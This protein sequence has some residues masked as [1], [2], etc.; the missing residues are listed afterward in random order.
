MKMQINKIEQ[1]QAKSGAIFHKLTIDGKT[2]NTFEPLGDLKVG[3]IV[4]CEFVQSGEYTNIKT[5]KKTGEGSIN[6]PLPI[7]PTAVVTG[8]IAEVRTI[9]Q[10]SYEVGKAGNRHTIRY[11]DAEDL[12]RQI[13]ALK[14]AGFWDEEVIE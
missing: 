8:G 14:E 1:K 2:Y 9:F 6:T 11:W 13:A 10:N 3:D 5:I 12:K 4:E 7:N